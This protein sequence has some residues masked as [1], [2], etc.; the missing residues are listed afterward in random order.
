MIATAKQNLNVK[1]IITI[2]GNIDHLAWA[3][4]HNLPSLDESLNLANYR[5]EFDKITQIHYVGS[6]DKVMPPILA[7]RFVGNESKVVEVKE[8]THNSGWEEIYS[9]IQNQENKN[10]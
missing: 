10:S 9:E 7:R 6:K 2:A 4:Y 1:K 8:A 5:D 3:Q